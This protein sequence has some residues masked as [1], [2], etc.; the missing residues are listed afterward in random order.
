[1][2]VSG[3]LHGYNQ[4]VYTTDRQETCQKE[5]KEPLTVDPSKSSLQVTIGQTTEEE[6]TEYSTFLLNN[7]YHVFIY[8]GG[9]YY[10]N[11]QYFM[12]GIQFFDYFLMKNI[13]FS[14]I[15]KF[16]RYLQIFGYLKYFIHLVQYNKFHKIIHSCLQKLSLT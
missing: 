11:F 10:N 13:I 7:K 4:V 12:V 9:Q 16:Y 14:D 6:I 8:M 3:S 15:L 5:Q 2:V 1:M